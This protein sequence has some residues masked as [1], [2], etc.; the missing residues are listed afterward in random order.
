MQPKQLEDFLGLVAQ[1]KSDIQK[2]NIPSTPNSVEIIDND[3]LVLPEFG[4]SS[5]EH[6]TLNTSASSRLSGTEWL[7][8]QCQLAA[9]ANSGFSAEDLQ[10]MLTDI[11][12]SDIADSELQ[13]TLADMLGFDNLGLVSELIQRRSTLFIDEVSIPVDFE[14]G[15]LLP[16]RFV[17]YSIEAVGVGVN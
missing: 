14:K 15:S 2:L 7:K 6:D 11:L 5:L 17:Q 13:G 10:A 1:M 16:I 3:P 4:A 8:E 9:R 12:K